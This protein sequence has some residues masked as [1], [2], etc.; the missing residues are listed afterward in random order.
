[1]QLD[2]AIDRASSYLLGAAV[3][4][5]HDPGAAARHHREAGARQLPPHLTAE[6]IVRVVFLEARRAE[7][8]HARTDEVKG[9]EAAHKFDHDAQGSDELR[10]PGLG[11]LQEASD[12]G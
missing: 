10:A 1:V 4:G 7:D 5:L 6:R 8:R 3:G 9:A 2:I 12:L 11:A